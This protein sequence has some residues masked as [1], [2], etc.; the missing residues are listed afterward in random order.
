[1]VVASLLS[2]RLRVRDEGLKREPLVDR[3]RDALMGTPGVAQ[4]DA[5]PRVG[6]L[7]V[8]YDAALAAAEQILKTIAELLGSAG[9]AG[10]Q[11]EPRSASGRIPFVGK[12]SLSVSPAVRRK[13]VNLGM[14]ASLLLSVA[15]AILD[16]KKLHILAGVVF[17]ALFGDHFF[18]RREQ[19]FA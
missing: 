2:G 19:M 10:G 13:V 8:L 16:F 4:V 14:L 9:E 7:L 6:S 5:N 18:Q 17:L 11:E 15:A 12:A 1:M 3:V